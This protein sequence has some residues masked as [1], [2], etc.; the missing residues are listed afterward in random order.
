MANE[1]YFILLLKSKK[2]YSENTFSSNQFDSQYGKLPCISNNLQR[3]LNTVDLFEDNPKTGNL[4]MFR[5]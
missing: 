5:I 4:L 2:L 1:R 3:F